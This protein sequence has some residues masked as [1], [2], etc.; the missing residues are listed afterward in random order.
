MLVHNHRLDKSLSTFYL[1]KLRTMS[2]L[3]LGVSP[4][5]VRHI[6]KESTASGILC[7]RPARSRKVE[8]Q[9]VT[10][11]SLYKICRD[12]GYFQPGTHPLFSEPLRCLLILPVTSATPLTPPS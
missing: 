7:F 8:N 3:G 10:Y 2:V 4:D 11:I 5:H 12:R 9:S 6:E 1:S